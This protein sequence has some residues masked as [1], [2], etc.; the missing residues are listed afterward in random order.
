MLNRQVEYI[1][2]EIVMFV[3]PSETLKKEC[4]LTD[5][6]EDR[7]CSVRSVRVQ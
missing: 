4:S 1:K 6:N 3:V 7:Y 2:D 5:V